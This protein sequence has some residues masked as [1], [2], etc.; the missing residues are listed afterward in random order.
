MRLNI[1]ALKS[2]TQGCKRAKY[3]KGAAPFPFYQVYVLQRFRK[4]PHL[5]FNH[6]LLPLTETKIEYF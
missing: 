3:Y 5:I 1:F 4:L 2:K 6:Q